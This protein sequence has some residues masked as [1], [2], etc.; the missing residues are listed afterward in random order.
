M[1]IAL[2]ASV[3]DG[4]I[5]LLSDAL[6]RDVEIG[7]VRVSPHVGRNLAKLYGRAGVFQDLLLE[8]RV[9]VT[10]VQED[11]RIVKPSVEVSLD[12]LDRLQYTL[13]LFIPGKDDKCGIGSWSVDLR[14]RVE[15]ARYE[16]F[17]VL[18][19]YFPERTR[20]KLAVQAFKMF[21][22]CRGQWHT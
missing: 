9:E 3:H 14:L 20:A 18:F 8:R 7:P 17:V 1:V 12:R 6:F 21:R 19:A 16:D 4:G 10:I 22:A 15:T 2:H 11:V 13:Q 5:T